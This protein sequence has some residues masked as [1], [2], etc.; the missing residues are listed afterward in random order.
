MYFYA[1]LVRFVKTTSKLAPT[2]SI[3]LRKQELNGAL[4][5]E[6]QARVVVTSL[7]RTVQARFF[8]TDSSTGRHWIR[9]N[10]GS[11]LMFVSHRIGEIQTLTEPWEWPFLPGKLS[12]QTWLLGPY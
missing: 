1:I 6:R 12:R 8:S 5:G 3:S 11:Y 10:G 9:A 7:T 4:L 2:K